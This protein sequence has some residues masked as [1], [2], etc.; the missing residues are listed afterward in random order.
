MYE[1]NIFFFTHSILNLIEHCFLSSCDLQDPCKKKISF[2][3]Q[4]FL[5]LGIG[6]HKSCKRIK[7]FNSLYETYKIWEWVN[8][9]LV[10]E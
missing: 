10:K 1:T 2:I 9:N 3:L 4:N 8:T 6:H 7:T 5:N